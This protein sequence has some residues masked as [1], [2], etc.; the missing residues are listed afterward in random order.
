MRGPMTVA[1]Y[2]LAMCACGSDTLT[3]PT[4]PDQPST[5]QAG[6]SGEFMLSISGTLAPT[7][8][9]VTVRSAYVRLDGGRASNQTSCSGD[10]GAIFGCN[11][12]PIQLRIV[13]ARGRHTLDIAHLAQ[14]CDLL[15]CASPQQQYSFSG[16]AMV[17]NSSGVLE[18]QRIPLAAQSFRHDSKAT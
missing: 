12:F 13:I 1:T 9:Y 18:L 10:F 3:Q 2:V 6:P 4:H 5:G 7:L 11:P 16:E 8:R 15:P 17:L 14:L